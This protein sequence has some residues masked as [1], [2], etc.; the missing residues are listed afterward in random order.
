MSPEFTV[1][2]VNTRYSVVETSHVVYGMQVRHL[3]LLMRESGTT[4]GSRNS[5]YTP[6]EWKDRESPRRAPLG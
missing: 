1:I 4:I 2:I 6:G 5:C 3:F